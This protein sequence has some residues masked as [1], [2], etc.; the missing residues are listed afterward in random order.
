MGYFIVCANLLPKITS[1][2]IIPSSWA[3]LLLV[4]A[5]VTILKLLA[6]CVRPLNRL[7]GYLQ[8]NV[9]EAHKPGVVWDAD[10]D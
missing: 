4:V 8:T 9:S 3:E 5:L 2:C 10:L 7:Q 1:L 6:T